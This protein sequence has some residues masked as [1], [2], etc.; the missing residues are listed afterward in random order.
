M[1]SICLVTRDAEAVLERALR[2]VAGLNAEVIVGDTGSK[3]GTLAL[4]Q[5]LGART[6]IVPWQKDFA[7]AQNLTLGQATGEWVL[8]LNPDEELLAQGLDRMEGLLARPEA[9]AYAVRVQQVMNPEQAEQSTEVI[10]P[11]LFR[12]RPDITFIG[13]LHPHFAEPLETLAR[14]ENMH[15][16]QAELIVRSHAYLSV[17]TEDKLRWVMSLLELELQDRPGQLHYLI[18][19]G[20]NLLRLNDPKGHVILAQAAEQVLAASKAPQA[21]SA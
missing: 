10:L 20:R 14:R 9:L 6:C 2:S 13:R 5:K 4:A 1:L 12:R 11:R 3:D 15:I 21:P 16:Y 17:L 18:E 19:Y 7:A 8:W